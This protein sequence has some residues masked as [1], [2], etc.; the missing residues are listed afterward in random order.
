[1]VSRTSALTEIITPDSGAA[2]D[3]DPAAIAAA[4][5]SIVGRPEHQRRVAARRRAEDFTWHRA[6]AGMLASMGAPTS[7]GGA[8]ERT[9]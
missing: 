1:M 3:N 8:S 9:A 4:V 7:T 2:A 5:S 6:A